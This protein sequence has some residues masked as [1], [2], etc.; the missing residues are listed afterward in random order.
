MINEAKVELFVAYAVVGVAIGV[1]L[2]HYWMKHERRFSD[3][4]FWA[5]F[6]LVTFFWP[7][8]AMITAIAVWTEKKRDRYDLPTRF[9]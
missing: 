5:A 4:R 8:A 6:I 2:I 3:G 7:V 1:G 9:G